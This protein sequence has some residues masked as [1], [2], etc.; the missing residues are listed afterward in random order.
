MR[1][2]GEVAV[3]VKKRTMAG[4]RKG[5]EGSG[6]RRKRSRTALLV[7]SRVFYK[8]VALEDNGV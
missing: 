6:L 7:E 8:N 2:G 5:R 4:R 3:E 1:D